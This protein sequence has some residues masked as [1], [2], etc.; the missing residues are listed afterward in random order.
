MNQTAPHYLLFT[1]SKDLSKPSVAC[2]RWRFVLEEIGTDNRFEESDT[3][4]GI[5]GERLELL[6]VVRGLEALEQASKIT[7]F[8]PSKYVGRGI[9][10]SLS[11][12]KRNNWCWES[13]GEMTPIKHEDLWRRIDRCMEIHQ[14]GCRV[15]QFDPPQQRT[16]APR[17]D[18]LSEISYR[19]S[20]EKQLRVDTVE[21]VPRQRRV[22]RPRREPVVSNARTSHSAMMLADKVKPI[23]S[24]RAYG[25]AQN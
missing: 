16:Q 17:E 11:Q 6:A 23:G 14:I 21:A 15:W 12:W 10:L 20:P 24:G 18:H 22:I 1:E 3:E 7:L 19:D 13:F 5:R 8:T 25:Y 9:R 2:G 4:L